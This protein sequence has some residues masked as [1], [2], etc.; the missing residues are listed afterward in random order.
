MKPEITIALLNYRRPENLA[1]IVATLR[2]QTCPARIVVWD[3]SE[4]SNPIVGVDA[5]VRTSKNMFCWPRW[6]LLAQAET[7]YCMTLDDDI[8]LSSSGG[9]E[10]ILK[11]LHHLEHDNQVLGPEGVVLEP[12]QPYFPPPLTREERLSPTIARNRCQH[13]RGAI[14]D[15]HVD[16][17]KGRSM[18][19]KTSALTTLPLFA[20]SANVCDDIVVSASLGKG[21][22]RAHKVPGAFNTLFCDLPEKNGPMALSARND[23][24]QT[25]EEARQR[26]FPA[27]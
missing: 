13:I 15:V 27:E 14:D 5:V 12:G 23:W 8:N 3:N 25:R 11:S 20:R 9:L 26:H 21:R 2:D 1:L 10:V 22:K 17:V 7:E 24:N 4:Q 16:V 18:A 19:M 6:L